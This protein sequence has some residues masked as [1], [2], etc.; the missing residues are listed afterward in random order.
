MFNYVI[1]YRYD[2]GA[3][4]SC[5]ALGHEIF[6]A[7]TPEEAKDLLEHVKRKSPN[8]DWAVFKIEGEP[9]DFGS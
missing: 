3:R 8:N 5:Y 7:D 2:P 4:L 6:H 9:Y 1:A